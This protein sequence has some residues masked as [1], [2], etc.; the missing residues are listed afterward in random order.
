MNR[1]EKIKQTILDFQMLLQAKKSRLLTK[2]R[3]NEE[4]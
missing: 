1:R 2:T 3:E 4:N